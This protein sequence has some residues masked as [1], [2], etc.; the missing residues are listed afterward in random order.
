METSEKNLVEES[1]Q[2]LKCVLFIKNDFQE[3]TQ[4]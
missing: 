3:V 4:G 1:H 2:R